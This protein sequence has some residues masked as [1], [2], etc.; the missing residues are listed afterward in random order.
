MNKDQ[1]ISVP[2]DLTWSVFE[3]DKGPDFIKKQ[4]FILFKERPFRKVF[5]GREV[6]VKAFR[7][8]PLEELFKRDSALKEFNISKIL[9]ERSRA[10]RPV[11]V[12]RWNKW[13]FFV[14]QRVEGIS[15]DKFLKRDWEGLSGGEKAQY[16]KKFALFLRDLANCGVIQPDFHLDNVLLDMQRDDFVLIDLHR[17]ECINRPLPGDLACEQLRYILPPFSRYLT[18]REILRVTV[19]ISRW[20]QELRK[21]TS[22]FFI[23][24]ISYR[25]IS[26]NC[27]K[28]AKRRLEQISF[29]R[30]ENGSRLLTTKSMDEKLAFLLRKSVLSR[31]DTPQGL[32]NTLILKNSRHTLCLRLQLGDSSFFIKCYRSSGTLKA[33]SY[34]IRQPRAIKT[35]NASWRLRCLGISTLLPLIAFQ[36]PNP[37]NKIYGFVAYPWNKEISHSKQ[38][39]SNLLKD[40]VESHILINRLAFFIWEMHQKGVFHGDCK[41]SNFVLSSDGKGFSVFDL[42][43]IRFLDTVSDR[44]RIKELAIMARSLGKLTD[45]TKGTTEQLVEAYCRYHVPWQKNFPSLVKR[46]LAKVGQGT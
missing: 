25:D 46:V 12:G 20:L 5:K 8:N 21:K 18:R 42:D 16:F 27:R 15:L 29:K 45:H 38:R 11:G 13:R 44:M 22:R 17:A 3:G 19:I 26:R 1:L 31:F 33:L 32:P 9:Y 28:K 39:I 6:F 35:W 14:S 10:P 2:S 36:T 24:Q 37:W 40:G 34:L 7:V 23:Q 43:S 4:E 41:I 30:E